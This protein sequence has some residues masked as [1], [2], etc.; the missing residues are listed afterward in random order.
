MAGLHFD[1]T[2]DNS[3]F[4][5]KMD[6][7]QNSVETASKVLDNLGKNFDLS[8]TENKILALGTVIKNNETSIISLSNLLKKWA[9]EANEAY[10]ANNTSTFEAITAGDSEL[11]LLCKNSSLPYEILLLY[12]ATI[13]VTAE[14]GSNI[15]VLYRNGIVNIDA[16]S[17]C[18]ISVKEI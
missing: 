5:K 14:K 9:E 4:L 17:S 11:H 13:H 2:A 10:N 7:I 12:G 15:K 18:N 16:D 1:V 3:N 8:T 6:E